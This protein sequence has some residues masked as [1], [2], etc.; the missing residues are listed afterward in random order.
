MGRVNINIFLA[1]FRVGDLKLDITWQGYSQQTFNVDRKENLNLS[2]DVDA[3]SSWIRC[4]FS[5]GP[6]FIYK[7]DL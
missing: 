3:F 7:T 2:I 6:E 1:C 4:D 5:P